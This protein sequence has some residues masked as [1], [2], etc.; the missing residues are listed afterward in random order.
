MCDD[1]TLRGLS[2]G[3]RSQRGSAVTTATSDRGLL[4]AAAHAASHAASH[5]AAA[6]A[7]AGSRAA[8]V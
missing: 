1:F 7:A 4:R 6:H 3:R 5:T 2:V 8:L